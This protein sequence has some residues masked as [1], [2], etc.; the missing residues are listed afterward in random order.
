MSARRAFSFSGSCVSKRRL[1][2]AQVIP[3][4]RR[5]FA[6]VRRFPSTTTFKSVNLSHPASNNKGTSTTTTVFAQLFTRLAARANTL[7]CR[8]ASSLRRPSSSANT[9]RATSAG[10]AEPNH[11]SSFLRTAGVWYSSR[12]SSSADTVPA[13]YLAKYDSAVLLPLKILPVRPTTSLSLAR[14]IIKAVFPAHTS[15]CRLWRWP[16]AAPAGARRSASVL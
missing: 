11:A 3:L 9:R 16:K 10:S 8:Q 5:R 12:T 14:R 7:G 2:S 15:S 6:S 1:Y 13:P 4:A